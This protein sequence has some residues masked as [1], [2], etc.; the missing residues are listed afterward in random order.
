[1]FRVIL[2][3]SLV[4]NGNTEQYATC[5]ELSSIMPFFW[6]A[7]NS[8]DYFNMCSTAYSPI[9]NL[10]GWQIP[11]SD[12]GYLGQYCYSQAAPE[13]RDFLNNT[14]ISPLVSGANYCVKFY[15][16]LADSM[17]RGIDKYG[18]LISDSLLTVYPLQVY[19]PQI[20]NPIGNIILDKNNWTEISG[21][22]T[23]LGGEQYIHLGNFY[24][25]AN[26]LVG[27]NDTSMG[28]TIGYDYRN[29]Y[30]YLDD[31]SLEEVKNATAGNDVTITQGQS[32]SI[33]ANATEVASYTWQV[34]GNTFSTDPNVV[35]N[36]IQT[37]SY[38]V[39]KNQCGITTTDTVTVTVNEMSFNLFPNPNNGE[40]TL[41]YSIK[42]EALLQIYNALGQTVQTMQLL[43]VNYSVNI[44]NRNLASGVYTVNVK[45]G[46]SKLYRVK[47]VLS[48]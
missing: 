11:H 34:N 47:M 30:Y 48:K 42:D 29:A 21:V 15:I 46:K 17:R 4:P 44:V 20:Q 31:V 38:V 40:F 5:P 32:V 28:T 43:P 19:T 18:I 10:V 27:V 37:S 22:Y 36:P 8:S 16:S 12:S 7:Y 41:T 9:S 2:V 25:D 26:T 14:L 23:A 33:G 24:N 6:G 39:S 45:Q 1:V 13:G 3:V 35:V